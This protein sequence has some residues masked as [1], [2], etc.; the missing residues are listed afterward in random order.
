MASAIS[1]QP[2]LDGRRLWRGQPAPR[3]ASNEPTGHAA[4]DAALA[5]GGWPEAALTEVLLPADGLG[6][7]RL[8]MPTLPGT[9]QHAWQLAAWVVCAAAYATHI[10]YEHFRLHNRLGPAALHVALAVALGA[11][12]L[13]V[14]AN[15]HSLA[16]DSTDQ[17]H[18]RLLLALAIWPVMTALPAYLFAY[19]ANA[20]LMYADNRRSS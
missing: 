11:F 20:V 12:G 19:G 17:Q 8:L 3:P 15:I 2:L 18:Q 13:A 1:L 16:V 14:G 6:E 7:L 10:A 9:H 4:L 5:T